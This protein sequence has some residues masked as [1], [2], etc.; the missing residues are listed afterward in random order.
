MNARWRL[1][2]AGRG[3]QQSKK[4]LERKVERLET[5]LEILGD[6]YQELSNRANREFEGSSV[7]YYLKEKIEFLDTLLKTIESNYDHLKR[8]SSRQKEALEVLYKD[9]QNLA[10]QIGS[11]Y[12]IGITTKCQ[13]EYA[14]SSL[15][16]EI[17]LLKSKLQNR[18]EKINILL[19]QI[20][21]YLKKIGELELSVSKKPHVGRNKLPEDIQAK[22]LELSGKCDSEGK[23]Y[24]I[25]KISQEAGC[26]IGAVHKYLKQM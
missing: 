9:N 10:A 23:P 7:Y 2:M 5:E 12:H 13:E 16:D 24:S 21:D 15:K 18:E 14:V 6:R 17:R 25:R 19:D 22:I 3:T 4:Y 20:N 26:S 1:V 8:E 11:N